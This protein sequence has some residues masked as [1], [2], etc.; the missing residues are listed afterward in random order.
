MLGR[1]TQQVSFFDPEFVCAHLID[2]QSFYA[3]MREHAES[4]ISDNDFADIYSP[5]N[6]R[7][8]CLQPAW[9]R[10]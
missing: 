7:L 9:P 4:I 6:D 3:K 10:S 5:D 8:Q 1:E 2:T